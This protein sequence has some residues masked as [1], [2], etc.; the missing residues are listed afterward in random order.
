[1][2]PALYAALMDVCR[3]ERSVIEDEDRLPRMVRWW[4]DPSCPDHGHLVEDQ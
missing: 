3:C 1:V 2:T 4:T